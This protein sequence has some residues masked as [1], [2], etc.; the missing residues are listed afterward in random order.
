[1]FLKNLKIRDTV[2]DSIIRDISFKMGANF[3]VDSDDSSKHNK[4]GKTT[5]LRLID[6]ALGAKD[7]KNIYFDSETNSIEPHV[8]NLVNER[9]IVVELK[10]V[11]NFKNPSEF[12][13][14]SVGLY[15]KGPYKIDG[16]KMGYKKYLEQLNIIFFK[17]QSK[18]TFRQ[19][20]N[21]FVRISMHGDDNSF[22]RNS[23]YTTNTGYRTMY[24]Y[25]F[26][27]SDPAFGNKRE[28][29][30]SELKKL[31][32]SLNRY[33]RVENIDNSDSLNQ[34]LTVLTSYR[35]KYLEEINDIVSAEY[36]Q[37]NRK[38]IDDVREQYTKIT[39]LIDQLSY[40][41]KLNEEALFNLDNS[42]NIDN[43]D[44]KSDFFKEVTNLLPDIT[45]TFD[46]LVLF[47]Q[48]LISNK[49][50]YLEESM[51]KTK[52]RIIEAEKD[53]DVLINGNRNLIALVQDN[54]IDEYLSLLK[55]L[56]EV[57]QN[58]SSKQTI[59]KTLNN[60][61]ENISQVNLQIE[62][63]N[64]KDNSNE[65][66]TK[67]MN[68]FNEYFVE[69]AEKISQERP[70]L[71][72]VSD[73]KKFPVIITAIDGSSTGTRKSLIAAYDLAYQ[74]FAKNLD[75][76]VPN[77]IIHDV[78]ENIESANLE[79]I[80]TLAEET[81]SQYIVAILQENLNLAFQNR[82]N[83]YKILELSSEHKLFD[84]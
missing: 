4:V 39:T 17:N 62:E 59:L 36:F 61:D 58:I 84:V 3:I 15:E 34:I 46:E 27:I 22:L 13:L 71:S 43:L 9:K 35:T 53:R 29:L 19:L 63:L 52:N 77:F 28:E 11:D 75:K 82:T 74:A 41:N 23:T 56:S 64:N 69:F 26:G 31:K 44:V 42:S 51:A 30:L 48:K 14:L 49:K 16:K 66:P 6:V 79:S 47:N 80:V 60:Y 38:R 57:E 8:K 72:Y 20:I 33:K 1:M 45:K 55:K 5:F 68:L 12:H 70:V 10:I 32:A 76:F 21:F 78:I 37:I 18:P 54:K 67:R 81:D 65:E 83:D 40:K 50:K 7:K 25:L 24:D 2:D 73:L